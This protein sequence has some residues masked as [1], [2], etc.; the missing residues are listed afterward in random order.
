LNEALDR[1]GPLSFCFEIYEE[2]KKKLIRSETFDFSP[3][4]KFFHA[5]RNF[6]G[7]SAKLIITTFIPK[8]LTMP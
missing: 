4:K 2:S 6:P 5:F 7:P 8:V 3:I 1:P